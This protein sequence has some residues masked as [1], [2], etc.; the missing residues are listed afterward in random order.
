MISIPHRCSF[1]RT[2][3]RLAES[4]SSLSILHAGT[5]QPWQCKNQGRLEKLSSLCQDFSAVHVAAG[6]LARWQALEMWHAQSIL[7]HPANVSAEFAAGACVQAGLP[8]CQRWPGSSSEQGKEA[9]TEEGMPASL[10]SGGPMAQLHGP[11][12]SPAR[13]KPPQISLPS[14]ASTHRQCPPRPAAHSKQIHLQVLP[15]CWRSE[16]S[17]TTSHTSQLQIH[18]LQQHVCICKL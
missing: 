1:S 12:P 17:S 7:T 11:P 3:A 5:F 4:A 2:T 14:W 8:S 9:G 10:I 15:K 13:G 16:G 18:R 6:S